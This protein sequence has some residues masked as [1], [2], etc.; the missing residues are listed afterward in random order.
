[1]FFNHPLRGGEVVSKNAVYLEIFEGVLFMDLSLEI[2]PQ[3]FL[4]IL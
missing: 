3:Q 2:I 1:M 4:A